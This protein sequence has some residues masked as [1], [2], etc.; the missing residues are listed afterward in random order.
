MTDD[1]S[2]VRRVLS[3]DNWVLVIEVYKIVHFLII[4]FCKALESA[5]TLTTLLATVWHIG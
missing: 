5:N 1:A 2:A 3:V 4:L